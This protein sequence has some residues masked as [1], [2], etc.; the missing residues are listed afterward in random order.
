M[1]ILAAI[2]S[3]FSFT[4][5]AEYSADWSE[6]AIIP[7]GTNRANIYNLDAQTLE[8][9]KIEGYKHAMKYP[10]TVTGLLIPYQPMLNFFKTDFNNPLKKLM[11]ELSKEFVGF[12]N[13]TE[14]YEWIGLSPFNSPDS[15][16]IY[17]M[18]YPNGKKD[19]FLVGAGLI[20]TSEGKGLTFSCFACHAN[21]LFGK[22][23]MGLTNKRPQ[24]NK[25][26]HMA[27]KVV[28]YIPNNIFKMGSSATD[29]EVLMFERAKKNL[30]SV[31]AK[32][33]KALGLDTSLPQ[34]AL[35]LARRNEDDYATKNRFYEKFPRYNEL[36]DH[37]A[38]SKPLPWWNLKY[39]THWLADGSIVA[40]NPILTNIL[41]NEIGRG[42]DLRELEKWMQSNRKT[43]DELT[44]AAFAT[45]APRWTDFFPAETIHL[46][47]AKR[48][49]QIFANR[50]QKCHGEY[51]KAWNEP[52]ADKLSDIE[53]LATTNVIYH[54][55]TPV[56]DV[57]TDNKRVEGI[58]AFADSLNSLSISKWMKT[59]VAPQ[60]GYVPPPLV[61][62][63][64]RYP[65]MHN[66]SIP[67]LCALLTKPELRPKTFIQGPSV[68]PETD[69]DKECVGYPVGDKIPKEWQK[70]TNAIYVA[71]RPGQ[72]N[73]GH[74]KMIIGERGEELLSPSEKMDLIHFMKTL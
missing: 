16:G 8:K 46:D 19:Q 4:A 11:L 48:G 26:F 37:V 62:I 50:C 23:V 40:G 5:Q 10:V 38:D 45:E 28:P 24:S 7:K 57:G 14:L 47:R 66:N 67:T 9:M 64:S 43:I 61:G 72:D 33:P 42:S 12:K 35:S 52:G 63:W 27:R 49:Q 60:S 41:W 32:E 54:E 68:N 2:F 1:F 55:Q 36:Q 56:K 31:G 30:V 25:F 18:P 3:M 6:N 69:F 71:G 21:N 29:G 39:K 70:D 13:E 34:V 74:A 17:K 22:T 20:E 15:T 58:K 73:G 59:V 53:I 51:Q 44:V 65:Y